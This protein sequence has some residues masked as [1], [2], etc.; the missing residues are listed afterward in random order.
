MS[1]YPIVDWENIDISQ[2][3]LERRGILHVRIDVPG[4][5]QPLHVCCTH[6][7]LLHRHRR[8]QVSQL[9]SRIRE[10][11]PRDCPLIIGGDFNDW[12]TWV[13]A[14]LERQ[15]GVRDAHVH[16]RGRHARTFP[17]P[18]PFLA[19]DRIYVRGMEVVDARV[20]DTPPWR[21]LSDH[22]GLQATLRRGDGARNA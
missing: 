7:N 22:L 14:E 1:R 4:F 9:A 19:L 21:A 3:P 12:R 13:T 10:A 2:H 6:L 8:H 20:L 18:Y 16:A 5:T 15:I 17:A 11:V